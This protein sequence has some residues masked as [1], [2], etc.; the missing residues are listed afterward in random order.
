MVI[1]STTTNNISKNSTTSNNIYNSYNTNIHNNY[2]YQIF[3]KMPINII[4][5]TLTLTAP[6]REP[7]VHAK[8]AGLYGVQTGLIPDPYIP[9]PSRGFPSSP[10]AVTGVLLILP[11]IG[12]LIEN[13]D[14]SGLVLGYVV[15]L[16]G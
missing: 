7:P 2:K 16:A 8:S 15:V 10:T 1:T 3:I 6:K 13:N 4:I 12:E 14:S 11:R 5:M 9:F